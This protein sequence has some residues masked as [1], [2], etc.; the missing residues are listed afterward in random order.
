MTTKVILAAGAI[1]GLAIAGATSVLGSSSASVVPASRPSLQTMPRAAQANASMQ[2]EILAAH[3][4]YRTAVKV[5]SLVWSNTLASHAQQWANHLASLGGRTLQHSSNTGEGE[6]LWLGTTGAFSY[7]KMVDL[8]GAEKKYFVRGTFPNVS[9]TGNWM[10]VG[11]YT[12]MIWKK[13][14]QVGCATAKA[15]GNDILVCRYS[16]PGNYRGQPVY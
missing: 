3:N 1:A 9:S 2:Q 5:P 8:W 12:Q 4:K 14:T 16:P 11:H 10:A 6:N 15:G 7:T 13:T